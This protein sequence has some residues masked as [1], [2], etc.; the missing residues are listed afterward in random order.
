MPSFIWNDILSLLDCSS[1]IIINCLVLHQKHCIED[2]AKWLSIWHTNK[3]VALT[4]IFVSIP[5]DVIFLMLFAN[6]M[7]QTVWLENI[8]RISEEQWESDTISSQMCADIGSV[9][10][11]KREVLITYCVW[12]FFLQ[13]ERN[14]MLQCLKNWYGIQFTAMWP[15]RGVPTCTQKR[16][17]VQL[18]D[19]SI[20]IGFLYT[21]GL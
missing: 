20:G 15:T 6:L 4:H 5:G 8:I 1:D 10:Q 3:T 9:N 18:S 11:R 19:A 14:I 2:I 12:D 7:N 17:C 21:D 16:M 13:A